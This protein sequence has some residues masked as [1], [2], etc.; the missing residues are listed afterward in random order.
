MNVEVTKTF[1]F[2]FSIGSNFT[3]EY[4]VSVSPSEVVYCEGRCHEPT[5]VSRCSDALSNLSLVCVCTTA[6]IPTTIPTTPNS[7]KVGIATQHCMPF[8]VSS[9]ASLQLACL[10]SSLSSVARAPATRAAAQSLVARLPAYVPLL[11]RGAVHVSVC[12]PRQRRVT[13]Q[14]DP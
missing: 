13:C 7:A 1:L 12:V 5:Y 9:L 6:T 4:N 11:L 14:R 8:W 2:T 10:C 3:I